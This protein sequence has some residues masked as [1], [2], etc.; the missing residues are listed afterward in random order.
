VVT[1]GIILL[2][3]VSVLM[4]FLATSNKLRR[5]WLMLTGLFLFSLLVWSLLINWSLHLTETRLFQ[6]SLTIALR[7]LFSR[8]WAVTVYALIIAAVGYFA[9]RHAVRRIG[10]ERMNLKIA[11]ECFDERNR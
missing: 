1:V 4:L 11:G 10:D 7:F 5:G 3:L 6:G 8:S 2:P 9:N